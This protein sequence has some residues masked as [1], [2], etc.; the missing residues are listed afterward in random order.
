[1]Y[2]GPQLGE[3]AWAEPWT[4]PFAPDDPRP[5]ALV[6]FSTTFQNHAGVLRNVIEAIAALPMRAVVTLGGA[7][8]PHEV[9][10]APNV[11]VVRSA[12]HHAVL[13][14]VQLAITH[15]GHGTVLKALA[16]GT[17][18]LVVPHGRDQEDNAVRVTERGAG[19]KVDRRAGV[20]EIRA[21][22]S[23]LIAEPVFSDA[24]RR[25]G[26]RIAQDAADTPIIDVLEALAGAFGS[27]GA[28]PQRLDGVVRARSARSGRTRASGPQQLPA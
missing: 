18:L 21:A 2:V 24:A 15:G 4:S 23:R 14:E 16:N 11:A 9:A 1:M 6:S 25:L 10:S 28:R 27:P 3:P 26:A 5:L 7:I 17:P 8:E 20:A 13:R 19:L 12:P 22:I